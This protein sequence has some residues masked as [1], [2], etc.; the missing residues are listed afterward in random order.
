MIRKATI[1]KVKLT[2]NDER[3][4]I[5]TPGSSFYDLSSIS[6]LL[7]EAADEFGV[8]KDAEIESI[9]KHCVALGTTRL[10]DEGTISLREDGSVVVTDEARLARMAGLPADPLGSSFEVSKG[11]QGEPVIR[12]RTNPLDEKS[13]DWKKVEEER[14]ASLD[15]MDSEPIDLRAV[16]GTPLAATA[17]AAE[18]LSKA[19]ENGARVYER[20]VEAD[21]EG[22]RRARKRRA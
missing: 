2:G 6:M 11:S 22:E 9:E 14:R 5:M 20:S 15:R 8:S 19:V 1:W 3:L 16:A 12:S 13:I 10:P 7:K 4:H 21:K 18:N 17:E